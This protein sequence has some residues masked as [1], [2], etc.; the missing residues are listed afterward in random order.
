MRFRSAES[1][2]LTSRSARHAAI[3]TR[4]GPARSRVVLLSVGT[5]TPQLGD[6]RP[7]GIL[8]EHYLLHL[9]RAPSAVTP[10]IPTVPFELPCALPD[11]RDR[12]DAARGRRAQWHGPAAPTRLTWRRRWSSEATPFG[13]LTPHYPV[14][15]W[16]P[17]EII[18][19][20]RLCRSP[21]RRLQPGPVHKGKAPLAPGAVQF[22][23]DV[24]GG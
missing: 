8:D 11:E 15:E 5:H 7:A 13:S 14:C 2:I 24:L 1:P 3:F 6:I 12:P 19:A 17:R 20:A 10:A 18:H 9:C 22:G 4:R 21:P 16:P 23:C